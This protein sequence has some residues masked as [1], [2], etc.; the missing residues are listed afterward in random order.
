MKELFNKHYVVT[1]KNYHHIKLYMTDPNISLG[2]IR[3]LVA[4]RDKKIC[5][6]TYKV[7]NVGGEPFEGNGFFQIH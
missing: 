7:L 3:K 1:P 5:P 2:T 6:Q 4:K